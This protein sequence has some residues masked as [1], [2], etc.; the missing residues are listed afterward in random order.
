MAEE[1]QEVQDRQAEQNAQSEAQG[2]LQETRRLTQSE[3]DNI[4]QDR[5]AR[6]RKKF[7]DYDDLKSKAS[8]FDEME[9]ESLSA[10]E[11]AEKRAI[12]AEE[13]STELVTAMKQN[14]LHSSILAEA[15]KSGRN[16]VDPEAVLTFLTGADSEFVS[17]DDDGT[18]TNVAEAMDQLLE[19]RSYLVAS[20]QRTQQSADQGARGGK[21]SQI[22]Q[23]ELDGMTAAQIVAARQEGRLASLLGS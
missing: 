7:A 2:D 12:A 6:E 19:K 20:A 13:R 16:V 23:G 3:V 14:R 4:V 10:Q 18:P 9:A 15:G 1:T 22:T 5:L 11:K 21:I 17:I 8:R